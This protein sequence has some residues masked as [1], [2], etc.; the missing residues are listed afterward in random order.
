MDATMTSTLYMGKSQ[1]ALTLSNFTH[2]GM[3]NQ[4]SAFRQHI[5]LFI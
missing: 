2:G 4:K 1:K 5:Q 3:I